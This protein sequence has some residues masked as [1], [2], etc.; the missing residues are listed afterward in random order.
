MLPVYESSASLD[1]ILARLQI[2]LISVLYWPMT[3]MG[4]A[5]D[6]ALFWWLTGDWALEL[7]IQFQSEFQNYLFLQITTLV[8][9]RDKPIKSERT[10]R[11]L[12]RVGQ[13]VSLAVERFVTVGESIAE[14]NPDIRH[15]M[16][17]ACKEAKMAG[18]TQSGDGRFA[19]H[20]WDGHR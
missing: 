14:E 16:R 3:G 2:D 17:E 1:L 6:E 7:I 11:A 15:D 19:V 4:R 13:A 8:N 12:V 18:E 9:H 10:L 5:N 20:T